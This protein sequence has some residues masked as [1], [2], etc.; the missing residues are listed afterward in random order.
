VPLNEILE[1]LRTVK[2]IKRIVFTKYDGVTK[3]YALK[4]RAE[5]TNGWFLDCW[6]HKTQ[7]TRRYSFHVFHRN[8]MVVRWDN[9]PH[10]PNLEGFPHHKHEGDNVIESENMTILKVLS[11]LQK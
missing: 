5:L 1:T 8:K 2:I 7:K 10:Y 3:V 6:E 9:T 11:E 4:V